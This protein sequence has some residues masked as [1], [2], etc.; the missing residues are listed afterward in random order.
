[1]LRRPLESPPSVC[2]PL[3]IFFLLRLQV[4]VQMHYTNGTMATSGA[5]I[6]AGFVVSMHYSDGAHFLLPARCVCI[7]L[8]V[9]DACLQGA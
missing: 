5:S 2:L 6:K 7:H 9:A 3:I 4:S 1:M 8:A